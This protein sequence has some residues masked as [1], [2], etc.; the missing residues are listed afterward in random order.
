M[1]LISFFL[2]TSVFS[3]FTSNTAT[4]VLLA[5]VAFEV[6]KIMGVNPSRC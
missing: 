6:A 4:A 1:M 2:L 5:P 3:Q